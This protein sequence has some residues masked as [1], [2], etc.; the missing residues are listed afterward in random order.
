METVTLKSFVA[1]S[2]R[3]GKGFLLATEQLG[4]AT[5][6]R[7][8][9]DRNSVAQLENSGAVSNSGAL[10]FASCRWQVRSARPHAFIPGEIEKCKK[11]PP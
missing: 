7:F 4:A 5:A 3:T 1:A 6:P 11:G 8:L 10:D 2:Y 9:R